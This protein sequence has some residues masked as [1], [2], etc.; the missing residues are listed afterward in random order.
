MSSRDSSKELTK[1]F[2][3]KRQRADQALVTLKLAPTRSQAVFL[4]KEGV[5][6]ANGIKVSRPSQKILISDIEIKKKIFYVGRGAHKLEG[7]FLKFNL[8]FQDK[9][10]ADIGASAGGFTDFCLKKGAKKIYAIDVGHGQ[11]AECLREDER[12]DNREGINIRYG[13]TLP[14]RVDMIVVDLSYISL[15]LVLKP[16]FDL[17]KEN[18]EGVLLVKP[19]FEIGPENVGKKGIVKNDQAVKD[20]LV[21]IYRALKAQGW[22]T[23]GA[24]RSPI[25]G[26]SGN[27]EYL[28]YVEK[29]MT[30]PCL[31]EDILR[32]L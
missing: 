16:V 29:G 15:L 10:I 7:A 3:Q 23:L 22:H 9:V 13:M 6:F 1:N 20:S 27:Q 11:L 4:I 17:L 5:V 21:K 18:G 8:S 19:Q 30:R 14:E 24:C 2:D 32:A 12:V 28:F 31:D 25:K 26:K